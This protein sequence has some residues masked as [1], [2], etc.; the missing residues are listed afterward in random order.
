MRALIGQVTPV[1]IV[2]HLP[3][4]PV[5]WAAIQELHE[6]LH[7]HAGFAAIQ[8]ATIGLAD[9]RNLIVRLYGFCLPLEAAAAV[10]PD[11]SKWLVD[12]LTTLGLKRPLHALPKC[13]CI[14][15]LD[16]A[17]L[18]PGALYVAEGSTLGSCEFARG[19]DRTFGKDDSGGRQFFIDRGPKTGEAR[20]GRPTQL[21]AARS[22][23]CARAEIIKGA[24]EAFAVFEHW[25]NGWSTTAYG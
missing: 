15:R 17:H 2:A 19:L 4:R 5:L 21:S 18:R 9:Y 13:S 7:R 6:C 11:R 10:R 12:D 14:P 3:L 24:I 23:P 8:S 20:R 16:S 25:L 1:R 22:E